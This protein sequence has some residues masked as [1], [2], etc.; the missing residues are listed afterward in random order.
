MAIEDGRQE[1]SDGERRH[2]GLRSQA[3]LRTVMN[4]SPLPMVL[5]GA[6]TP[7]YPV[8]FC[9]RAFTILTGFSEE[10]ILGLNCRF[11]QGP[12]TDQAVVRVLRDA[13]AAAREAQV[14]MWNYRKDGSRFWN[15]M[16]IGPVFGRDGRLMYYFGSQTDASARREAD[17]SRSHAQRMDTLGLMAA[18]V[19]H[20][21]NN[22]MTV[23][24][25]TAERL[26]D[27]ITEPKHIERLK[28]IDWAA[29]ETG[30]LTQQMLSFAG[31]QNLASAPVDLNDVLRQL[32]RL[33]VQVVASGRRVEVVPQSEPMMA[34]LDVGQLQLALINLVRNAS[35]ATADGGR[36]IVAT[37]N[38]VKDGDDAAEIFVSD[39]GS[40][41]PP[42][43]AKKASEPFFTT[44]APGK[45]TGLGLSVV[46]G[47]CQQSGGNMVIET[48]DGE[49][50]T[51]R[52]LFPQY[53]GGKLPK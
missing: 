12:D 38:C 21:V 44:K 28:R 2:T 13:V 10:E 17:E 49:G 8:I 51:V 48:K 3:I 11:L 37:R 15:S 35:D 39:N 33:L 40:G 6:I 9:N 43:I 45:G 19:A 22:L 30:K 53:R 41:M 1:A 18:G 29:R 14:D 27:V 26:I 16:Y 42:D 31:K 47:F 50:T 5:A 23:I 7:D 24:G 52:L 32:D 20:E 4:V 36:I 25:G 46:G 34:L